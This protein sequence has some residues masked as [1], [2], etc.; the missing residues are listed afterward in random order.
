LSY[1]VLKENASFA[2]VLVAKL[3]INNNF[4]GVLFP[5]RPDTVRYFLFGKYHT[6]SFLMGENI[7]SVIPVDLLEV[8]P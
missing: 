8:F 5:A 6:V 1:L 3:T 2:I 7:E 4:H